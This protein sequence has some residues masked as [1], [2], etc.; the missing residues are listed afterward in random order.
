V[1]LNAA[2]LRPLQ[3]LFGRTDATGAE[4][5][6]ATW[7]RGQ[8]DLEMTSRQ[9]NTTFERMSVPSDTYD[10]RT[11]PLII[12]ALPLAQGYATQINIFL[13]YTGRLERYTVRVRDRE[14]IDVP[15]G[16]FETWEVEL[17]NGERSVRY[18]VGVDAPYPVV[19]M[20]D[21][22]IRYAL[23]SFEPGAE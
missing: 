17:N 20:Q 14:Q 1:L 7:N 4:Q 12:R 9:Q 19:Q 11:L 23:E 5:V 10:Q 16:S 2:S 22:N 6:N 15:A 3:S 18:W 21:A 8:V 13:P